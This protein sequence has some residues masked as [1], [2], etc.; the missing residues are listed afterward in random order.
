[1]TKGQ[2]DKRTKSLVVE[3]SGYAFEKF[4]RLFM[5]LF[6]ASVIGNH[7]ISLGDAG[8][9]VL[10]VG[11]GGM[12]LPLFVVNEYTEGNIVCFGI[13]FTNALVSYT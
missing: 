10:F 13:A 3:K 6:Q 4:F 9:Q 11:V 7:M 8:C 5:K 2:K 12:H 1:M